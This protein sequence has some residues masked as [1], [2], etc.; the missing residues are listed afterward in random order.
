MNEDARLRR[1]NFSAIPLF[2]DRPDDGATH[3][4]FDAFRNAMV[5]MLARTGNPTPFVFLVDGKWGAGKTSL[6]RAVMSDLE[7]AVGLKDLRLAEVAGR[8]LP[9]QEAAALDDKR[10]KA[11][12]WPLRFAPR[13]V[14]ESV[15]ESPFKPGS[16]TS[17]AECSIERIE[18]YLGILESNFPNANEEIQEFFTRYRPVRTVFFNAWKYKDEAEIF[19]ALTHE[20]LA[21][22][23][24][25]G[26][27]AAFQAAA[28]DVAS[29]EWREAVARLAE[30]VP[31][32]G[33]ALA[34][35]VERPAWLKEVALYDR[36][37]PYIQGLTA[38]W[39]GTYALRADRIPERLREMLVDDVRNV[40]RHIRALRAQTGKLTET[41]PG[42]VAVFVD[43]LDR[44]P[45]EHVN[46]ILKAINL[47]VD[48]ESSA[49]V[50]GADQ[51]RVAEAIEAGYKLQ[52]GGGHDGYGARFLSKIVQLHITLPEGGVEEMR[53]YLDGLLG[54]ASEE[55]GVSDGGGDLLE[56]LRENR[57]L[58]G[59]GLPPNPRE[60]KRLLNAALM[61]MALLS[62]T[63]SDEGSKTEKR[64]ALLIYLL[65][66]AE[67]PASLRTDADFL[68][69]LQTYATEGGWGLR[70]GRPQQ[71]SGV[72]RSKDRLEVDRLA[73]LATNLGAE[74]AERAVRSVNPDAWHRILGVLGH[75]DAVE[76]PLTK[77]RIDQFA[78]FGGGF[79]RSAVADVT[80]V[81][82]PE[83]EEQRT[84]R[85][86][87]REQRATAF[88]R[89][90]MKAV[91]GDGDPIA[92]F[93]TFIREEGQRLDTEFAGSVGR[94]ATERL[95][96][97]SEEAREIA[98]A[99]HG[100]LRLAFDDNDVAANESLMGWAL[101]LRDVA[102]EHV[103]VSGSDHGDGPG[104]DPFVDLF[105][106]EEQCVI[107]KR[108]AGRDRTRPH[109]K[110][111]LEAESHEDGREWIIEG[112]NENDAGNEEGST[113]MVAR[114]GKDERWLYLP[115]GP[116]LAG[117][118]DEDDERPVR[119]DRGRSRGALIA[120]HPVRV[121]EYREF[122]EANGR[123]GT[124]DLDKPW[125]S[126]FV[127]SAR[128]ALS[129]REAPKSWGDQNTDFRMGYPVTGINWFEAVAYCRW[130][131]Y[132]RTGSPEG[133]YRLPTEAEWEMAARGI[134]GRRWPWG[135]RWRPDL[136][137]CSESG[138]PSQGK[139]A[140][141]D[142]NSNTSPF[143]VHGMAGNVWEWCGSRWQQSGFGK[144]LTDKE[145]IGAIEKGDIISL[146][147]GSFYLGQR[148]VR[149]AFRF[150]DFAGDGLDDVGFRCFRDVIR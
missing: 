117:G 113:V 115:P 133:P 52:G 18:W 142:E 42:I 19:P 41:L 27:L 99:A 81:E 118:I 100:V 70:I 80:D 130:L 24:E 110:D 54:N 8:K 7:P 20:L 25:D 68:M 55:K 64:R 26:W 112:G 91:K 29:T 33:G 47:L 121:R 129:G 4:H 1:P 61:R 59:C 66:A 58:L 62:A 122:L 53:A 119:V 124:Y 144:S 38:A 86:K 76:A 51:E 138:S 102:L 43:D 103:D 60:V 109:L 88:V 149:C 128:K 3:F 71:R 139:I 57:D 127:D 82:A 93:Q 69:G 30:A 49:W 145:A 12:Q 32:G 28:Q 105:W 106:P 39:A 147:G 94:A 34:T 77:E 85:R 31:Y 78:G 116:F 84:K 72:V 131:N 97:K 11:G 65:V 101:F 63:D 96:R 132:E 143:G 83:E 114:R 44:C 75:A 137:V 73:K 87:S 9:K 146:R 36:A 74:Q 6:M 13:A 140:L 50:L 150:G 14:L 46:E 89:G 111:V 90:L 48:M 17:E 125:W 141:V 108:H 79:E 22:M 10:Q 5:G 135:C 120:E 104:S 40:G 67:L 37:R 45:K 2:S 148:L 95:Q 126:V 35:V 15:C 98:Q 107:A 21:A 92:L 23:R 56:V 123:D 134:F 136:V 16:E